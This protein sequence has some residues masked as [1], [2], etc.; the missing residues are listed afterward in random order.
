MFYTHR[1]IVSYGSQIVAA[2]VIP[3]G[4]LI[5]DNRFV[6]Y[7]LR[8]ATRPSNTFRDEAV[9]RSAVSVKVDLLEFNT[10]KLTN[11][12]SVEASWLKFS[13][14][15]LATRHE[16]NLCFESALEINGNIVLCTETEKDNRLVEFILNTK[17]GH[18]YSLSVELN[19]KSYT[20]FLRAEAQKAMP[21]SRTM[22]FLNQLPF[23]YG[24]VWCHEGFL[25]WQLTYFKVSESGRPYY[26]PFDTVFVK[27]LY[28]ELLYPT[29]YLYVAYAP[30]DAF[31]HNIV[32]FAI[33]SH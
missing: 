30:N 25:P 10:Q 4:D 23:S 11:L 26:I 13:I 33:S 28:G 19:A 6:D 9:F 21:L 18:W 14:E 20:R 17:L 29:Y 27:E 7:S 32:S 24:T 31:R 22:N 8:L 12:I 2:D 15:R 16:F 3:Q 5:I 1:L